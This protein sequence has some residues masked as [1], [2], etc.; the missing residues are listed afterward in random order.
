MRKSKMYRYLGRNG[1]I[2]SPILLEKIE[3]ITMLHLVAGDDKMLTDGHQ[4]VKSV[5][6]FTEDV[7]EWT[8]IDE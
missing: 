7:D 4:V 3:P 5:T 1:I 8:E 2:T 6:I